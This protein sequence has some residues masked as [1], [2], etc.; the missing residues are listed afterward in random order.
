MKKYFI[1]LALLIGAA[2]CTSESDVDEVQTDFKFSFDENTE[3]FVGDFADY[4]VGSSDDYDLE[5]K[6]SKLPAPMNQQDGSLKQSGDNHSDD[7]FMFV[8]KKISGL[9]P[10]KTYQAYFNIQFAT[11]APDGSVGVGG[12]PGNSVYIKAGLT[13]KEPQ[14]VE[15]SGYYRMNIDKSNQS[16]GGDDMIVLGDF[17][18]DTGKNEYTFKVLANSEAFVV[19]TDSNGELWLI[20]GTDS[21]FES[22]TTIY[23][24]KIEVKFK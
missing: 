17:A 13:K 9:V 23:Y 16:N 19:E 3:G 12:S 24:N 5:F 2:A 4:P 15:Q 11:N 7:L 8:K 1:G 14:K 20:V 18:N 10:N 21:G 6:H 22:T